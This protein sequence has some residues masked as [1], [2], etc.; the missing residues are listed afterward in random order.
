M[1]AEAQTGPA[2]ERRQGREAVGGSTSSSR[3]TS[4]KGARL[5]RYSIFLPGSNFREDR[6]RG[7]AFVLFLFP[8]VMQRKEEKPGN[9]KWTSFN[10]TWG[11]LKDCQGEKE[12]GGQPAG[13]KT[14][15]RCHPLQ[16]S[17][18]PESTWALC[19]E[20]VALRSVRREVA[21]PSPRCLTRQHS[22]VPQTLYPPL[23]A[24]TTNTRVQA[25]PVWKLLFAHEEAGVL[26]EEKEEIHRLL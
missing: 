21:L 8:V 2:W 17:R 3:S 6:G 1:L 22:P 25:F 18:E 5:E 13:K 16:T 24:T 26:E 4:S 10:E 14:R 20:T 15:D 19:S 11:T 12:R 23:R 9:L 7:K